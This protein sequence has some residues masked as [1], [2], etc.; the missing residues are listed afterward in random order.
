[1]AVLGFRGERIAWTQRTEGREKRESHSSM[2]GRRGLLFSLIIAAC[3]YGNAAQRTA[4]AQRFA[5]IFLLVDI[6]LSLA[7]FQQTRT[8]LVRLVNQLNVRPSAHRF[9]LAQFGQEVKV[10]FLINAYKTKE[11]TMATWE[12]LCKCAKATMADIVFLV[13]GSS[14]I[15]ITNFQEVRQFLRNF[16]G[17]LDIGADKVRVG[18]AQY[19]DEPHQEFLLKDHMDKQSLLAEVD[20]LPYRTG[21]TATGKAMTFL[22]ERYFTAEA[23]SR[24]DQRVPQV[25]V[26]ITD[27]DSADDVVVPAQLLRRHGVIVFGIGLGAAN[28]TE[29]QA[30]TNRP[31][32]R[33][34]SSIDN[35]QALQR[36][37]DNLL[38]TVCVSMEDQRLALAQRFADIFFLVDSS[39]SSADF[40]HTRTLLDRL[41]NQLNVG[42]SA[43]RFGL[44]QFG[45]EVKVEFLLNAFKTK[46]E[47]MAAFQRF[48]LYRVQANESR[49]LG[50]A[51]Q[52]ASTNF[53]TS[54]AGSREDKSFRQFLV[55][56]SGGDSDDAVFQASRLVKSEG[57]TVV[58]IGLGAATVNEMRVV[59]TAPYIYQSTNI[60]PALKTLFETE[61]E[62]T[63]ITGDCKTA[64]LAD[65]VFIVDESG[66]IGTPNFQLVRTFLHKIVAGLDVSLN[67]VRV[68]IVMYN[69][70]PTAQ[71]Y[72]NT[73]NDKNEILQFIKILPYHGGGTNTG[74]A[75]K[76]AREKV[77]IKVKG[78]RK[79]LGIQQVA[80][81]ITDGESQD[82]VSQEAA[83]LR[84][85]GVTVYA[86]G[87][88]DA[89]KT[90]LVQMASY[91]SKKHVFI[92]DSF[93]KLKTLE[94]SLQK[95]LCH[96]IFR[97]A[98]TINTR[99]TGIKQGCV[100]TDEA[101]IF[102]LI[103]HSGS[104]Y[105][106]DF[107]DIKKFITEFIHTFN[108]GPQHVRVGV[109]KY[110]DSP[111][112]EFDLTAHSDVN[113]LEKAVK[114]IKQIGGGTNTGAAL[115]FM[116][117][118][119]DR[120][121][122]TRGHKVRE[123]LVVITDGKSADKVK[124]PA[125][126]LRAQGVTI[127]AIGVKNADETELEEIAG[128]PEKTFF[129]NDFD[130]LKPIKDD[131]ITDICSQ[132]VCKDVPGDLVFLIDSSGS[133][134]PPDFQ[135]MK[136]FMKSV[137][138][139]SVIRQNKVHIG[140]MQ[141]STIQRLEFPLN[142]YYDKGE[143]LKG[144]DDMQQIGGGT[145]T[146]GAISDVSQYFDELRGGRPDLRQKLILIT[147]SESQD[148]VK[149]P[150]EALRN[151]GVM[152]YAFGVVNANTTQLLEI[153]GS[154][155]RT[156]A[157]RDF[158]A[159]KDLES[160]VAMELC[161][162]EGECKTKEVADIIFLVDGST[163][164]TRP[165]FRS[166]LKFMAS[167]VNQNTVSEKLT[168]F[169]VILYS[170]DPTSMFTLNRYY[171]KREVLNAIAALKSPHG[172]T[173]TG[174]ALEYSLQFFDAEHGG[175]AASRVPQILM[176]ITDG[177][178]TD[179]NNLVAA[180]E[181]LRD[182]SIRVFSIGVEG[183]N[184]TQLEIM[185]GG[186]KS[187]VFYVDNFDAL[188]TLYINISHVLCNNTK[189]A[190]EKQKADLVILM[191]QSGSISPDDYTIMKIFATELVSSFKISE[192]FVRVGVAQF[193][194]SPQKEFYLNQ[195]YT[196]AEV[197]KH[198][199]D[200]TQLGGG[201]YIG[202]AL[203]FIRDYFRASR[204][205]RISAGISQNLVLIT[206][207]NSQD[208]VEDAA[209]RLRALGIEVFA[210]G[211]GSVH[212]MQLLLITGTP[213]RLLIVQNFGSLANIKQNVI[214]TICKTKPILD[215]SACSIDIV[216]GFDI[217]QRTGAPG[218]LLVSGQTKLQTF[219]PEI[220]HYVSSLQGLC[221][222]GHTPIKPNI[223]FRVVRQ[224]GRTLY[225]FSL[226]G[227][228]KD[229]VKKVMTLQMSEATYFNTALLHSFR[230][231]LKAESN[232][233][234][235]VLVIF[236]DGL[237]EDMMKL[238]QESELLRQSGVHALLTVALEGVHNASQLQ[239][240]E[241]GRGF[242]YK[243]PLSIGMQSIGSTILK[244]I[245]TVADRECCNVMCKASVA[246]GAPRGQR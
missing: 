129:V 218:Q 169:G 220:V 170:N 126:R 142:R 76:F 201:T 154:Q 60:V 28:M 4:L 43:H 15:G 100:Q 37:T 64:K 149:G 80:V 34:L 181:A 216:M 133:I 204:G 148:E 184:L 238:E 79:S 38:Q 20:N 30:I 63:N 110:T 99:R 191:D 136:D 159:L 102:F 103:D 161:D 192:E 54:E 242:G 22:R 24:A 221:C 152:I 33:F 177:D 205:S 217:S 23:G 91:P 58:G 27:G 66:S 137:I 171:S 86:V 167:M 144:I 222:T 225:D 141:Y 226:E 156:Y 88:K 93:A 70:R 236:S 71:V 2:E 147:D 53:F 44:A 210:I 32:Q 209:D 85:D 168:R 234:V 109:A 146:G 105:P 125:E 140:V 114:N 180:S 96:N 138:T 130:A 200:L 55:V 112:L 49:N 78:S 157:E 13:D 176:V 1:M 118:N 26:V 188:E 50:N 132:D 196:E 158:D 8:L 244:Q 240:V 36:L 62:V 197:N 75:L 3:F 77:F 57:V 239:M 39:L 74:A 106:N 113:S 193:S 116:G 82:V 199:L 7:D 190:C 97:Q 175:R 198:I 150:A 51:L 231:K 111:N 233:V 12:M 67:R 40:Q 187:R 117:P 131:I 246:L 52:Y 59:A 92:V 155:D 178:A 122:A 228:N 215:P 18:L 214:D 124:V 235:K 143:M 108:I 47:T 83:D 185:A 11:E 182:N 69:D 119:F 134:N 6:S 194:S 227:Y 128:S 48:R 212:D 151:K 84:R 61:E 123:Y 183:A 213:E 230:H 243:L 21:N 35:Y 120:A 186:D 72:L 89:K 165:K 127:Y 25:A 245:E 121:T 10:E 56:V 19:S 202:K 145:H 16:I 9:G 208:D 29:L 162:T 164:I 195:Y 139:K 160:E 229:V 90:E 42:A 206:D 223:A 5:D 45:Q 94:Q 87:I 46:E 166:M 31:H 68:G 95:I 207:G 224:D 107:Y 189:P 81:V 104:I 179:R 203:D 172:D 65:I 135:K 211:I 73:F 174:K 17:G 163:S 98:I 237:D 153:S 41:V 115:S 219:L 173:Y 14:S 101:D 232:A 241:F